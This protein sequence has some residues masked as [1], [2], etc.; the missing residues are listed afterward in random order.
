M[1][2]PA[3]L[4]FEVEIHDVAAL[5][6][7]LDGVEATLAPF[8][9]QVLVNGDN[10]AALEGEAPKGKVVMLRFESM[11]MARAWYASPAYQAILGHRL[12]ATTSRAFLV[13][14]L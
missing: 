12:N 3:Y 14:G 10:V 9:L 2:K 1:S 5:Q 7:Y 8:S 13:E 6:P 4:N 11:E